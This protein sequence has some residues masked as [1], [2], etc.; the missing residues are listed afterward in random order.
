MA[1]APFA[2]WVP[3]V[4]DLNGR[5]SQRMLNV[6]PTD[7][8]YGPWPS[9]Q[10]LTNA[11]PA[12]CRGYYVARHPTGV[13]IFA[14]TSDRLYRLDN[15]ILT[16]V[17]VSLSGGPYTAIPADGMWQFAQFNNFVL[18]THR[19]VLLQRFDMGTPATFVNCPGSPP[20]AGAIA[21]VNRFVVLSDLAA[22]PFRA[23]WSG[24][25]NTEQWTPGVNL[26][27]I[28]DFPDGGRAM[29]VAEMGQ[30]VGLILQE[31]AIRRMAFL[32]GDI[33]L[34]FQIDKLRDDTGMLGQYSLAVAGGAAYFLSHKG[35]V[36]VGIDSSMAP[37]GEE[38]VDRTF[39]R[40]SN[41]PLLADFAY[42]NVAPQMVIAAADPLNSRI[43]W[44]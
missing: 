12:T 11:L 18:A 3:D 43:V 6:V 7:S 9:M 37:I 39:L 30:D 8:A 10:A 17:D 26:S 25:N 16:W 20:Q 34:V 28:Q 4:A 38:M 24:L 14:G 36:A 44:A 19:N 33:E 21:V 29:R 31:G 23:Q 41:S 27:D 22:N 1:F 42:N 5:T 2:P 13:F 40:Q 15:S 35:F 32:P